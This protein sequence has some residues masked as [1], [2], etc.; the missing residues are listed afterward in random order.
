MIFDKPVNLKY[1]YDNRTF[2]C[3]GYS[4]DT[5][6]H[7]QKSISGYTRNQRQEDIIADQLALLDT[8]EPCTRA[9]RC[10]C[11]EVF[12]SMVRRTLS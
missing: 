11:K 7:K 4:V 12:L 2:W 8:V 9:L 1:K 10:V 3:R 5:I 6:G